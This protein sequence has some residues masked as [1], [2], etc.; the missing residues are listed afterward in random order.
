MW[1]GPCG[2]RRYFITCVATTLIVYAQR[3]TLVSNLSQSQRSACSF[4]IPQ[5]LHVNIRAPPSPLAQNHVISISHLESL[6]SYPL[7]KGVTLVRLEKNKP[8]LVFSGHARRAPIFAYNPAIIS[9]DEFLLRLDTHP[10]TKCSSGGVALTSMS[11]SRQFLAHLRNESVISVIHCAEDGRFFQMKGRPFA[12]FSRR[13]CNGA[14]IKNVVQVGEKDWLQ[15]SFCRM[16]IAPLD[17][18]GKEVELRYDSDR[19]D[20]KNWSPFVFNDVLFVSYSLCPH[21]VLQCDVAS[22]KCAKAYETNLNGC[23]SKLRGGTPPVRVSEDLMVGVAHVAVV[24]HKQYLHALYL[25]SSR[26]P[27]QL[28]AVSDLFHFGKPRNLEELIQFATGVWFDG[29]NKLVVSYGVG[30]CVARSAVILLSDIF[31]SK[32]QTSGVHVPPATNSRTRT[33]PIRH[34]RDAQTRSIQ[35]LQRQRSNMQHN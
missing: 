29:C 13:F 8:V 7:L 3:F 11:R 27:F 35:N 15:K 18:L 25:Q 19:G 6:E 34:I 26:P 23:N 9:P 4:T 10:F 5:G 32:N 2:G 1:Y 14:E 21:V 30:D 28:L 24:S 20:N 33:S 22:G 17:P 12:I 16:W 31:I